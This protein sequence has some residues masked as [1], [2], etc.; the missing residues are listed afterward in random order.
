MPSEGTGPQVA[1]GGR[2]SLKGI[3]LRFSSLTPLSPPPH[4]HHHHYQYLTQTIRKTLRR[5]AEI[6]VETN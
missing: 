5:G 3:K 2:Q 1:L 6:L 4:H